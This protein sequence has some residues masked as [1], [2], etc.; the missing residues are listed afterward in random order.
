MSR[1]VT[2]IS[3]VYQEADGIHEFLESIAAQTRRPDQVVITD[4]GSQD[5]TVEIIRGFTGLPITLEVLPGANRSR[6]RNQ[7]VARAEHDLIAAADAGCRLD[8]RWLEEITRPFDLPEPPDVVAGY[9]RP[10]ARTPFEQAV[11]AA[12]IPAGEEVD[13]NTFLPSGR[14]V[15][16]TR[17][18]W[19]KVGGYPEW[20]TLSEDTLFDLALRKAGCKFAFAPKA[21]ALWRPQGSLGR[22]FR[23]FSR[24]AASDGEQGLWF[25]HY[26]K[27]Y[28][29][30]GLVIWAAIFLPAALILLAGGYA[31]RYVS[32]SRRRGAQGAAALLSV[33]VMLTVDLAHALGYARGF[34]RRLRRGRPRPEA[35][36]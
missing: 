15:A 32:R 35:N 4:A 6:G 18:A 9:Y 12:T 25:G 10:D 28:L 21:Q 2:L 29:W 24:Y 11:A 14:S 31:L 5:G 20:A 1:P 7:A 3:T 8:P 36:P 27:A 13:E 26:T 16:F 34:L 30:W 33:P 19:A 22:V 17:E 23:Q